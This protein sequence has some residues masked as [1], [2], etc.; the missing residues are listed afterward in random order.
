MGGVLERLLKRHYL[1]N[2]LVSYSMIKVVLE[3]ISTTLYRIQSYDKNKTE[4]YNDDIE[5]I[6]GLYD[7]IRRQIQLEYEI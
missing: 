2:G 1:N 4:R 7:D 5:F 6:I 3:M